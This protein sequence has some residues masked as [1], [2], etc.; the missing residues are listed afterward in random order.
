MDHQKTIVVGQEYNFDL[1]EKLKTIL[2]K[3]G[4]AMLENNWGLAGS[5][6]YAELK[7]L[8]DGHELII[9]IETYSG[10][11]ITGIPDLVDRISKELGRS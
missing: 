4:A 8:I 2:H 9:E 1:I 6:E 11:S 7:M 5:Q 3:A 10:I